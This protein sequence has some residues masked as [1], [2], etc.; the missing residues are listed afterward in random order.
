M[1]RIVTVL[2]TLWTIAVV[3]GSSVYGK[4]LGKT[5]DDDEVSKVG[6]L[7]TSHFARREIGG[8]KT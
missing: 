7:A 1:K 2:V 3:P 5:S 6:S 8:R 4:R